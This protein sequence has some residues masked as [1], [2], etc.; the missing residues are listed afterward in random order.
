MMR[1]SFSSEILINK[2]KMRI[3]ITLLLILL[4]IYRINSAFA[5]V[6]LVYDVENTGAAC[7]A[8]PLPSVAQLQSYTNLPDPF[9]WSDGNG[10]ITHF[11]D[12][13]CR[14]NEIKQEIEKYEIGTKPPKPGS[15]T[16]TYS[17]GT[18]TVN[19]TE[20]G[21]TLTLTSKVVVPSGSGPFP[22]VIGM[23]SP[24]GNLPANLFNGVIQIPFNHDQ[25]AKYTQGGRD[26]SYPFFKLY[27]NL[28]SNGY[29]SAWAWGVSR[30]IDGI[31]IVKAQMNADTKRICVTGCSYAGKMALF[32]GAFDERVALTIAQ[33]S[34][35]GG[36]NAWRVS[37]TIGNVEKIDNTN[38]S[39]FMQSLKTNFQGA[40]IGK[41]PYD[42]HELMAMIAPRALLVLGNPPFQWL[43]DESGYV[44]CRAAQEVWKTLGVPD[45][46]GFSFRGGH[47]HC[48][49]PAASNSE[50]TAFV[51]KFLRN[52]T[53]A[54]TNIEVHPF[55]STNYIKWIDA[56]DGYALTPVNPN[57]PKTNL[58][59]P[60]D[61]SKFEAPATVNIA[62]SVTDADNNVTKIEFFAGNQKLGE[63]ATAPYSFSWT[64]VAAG[65]YTITA[66]ASDGSG[67]TDTSQAIAIDVTV[68]KTPFNGIPH[69]IPGVIEAEEYDLGG[70][71]LGYHE[72]NA[73]GNEGGN[74]FRNDQV[75]IETTEDVQGDYNVGYI[76]N[77]EWL[78]YTV[79]AKASGLYNISLRV[80]VDGANRTMHMEM[81]G[82]NITDAIALPN[83]GGWQTWQTITINNLSITAGKHILRLVFD[84]DYLNINYMDFELSTITS[85][86]DAPNYQADIFPNPYT[87]HLTINKKGAFSYQIADISGKVI[88]HGTGI[89]F[90]LVGSNLPNGLYFVTVSNDS[91]RSR[92][93]VMK[94]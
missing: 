28:T 65:N 70:E 59:S 20:N 83:T 66:V 33:E 58:T 25:V 47:D 64:N 23:N 75:D 31:E 72:V 60:V 89:D 36:V 8:P 44:S 43:G 4:N 16:A 68:P 81:D 15:V 52:N 54:N 88:E 94:K 34:G 48:S 82:L 57:A 55:G 13:K 80:A 69:A 7:T 45:R 35:G 61:G 9:A 22:V 74:P 63:D 19:V 26:P 24:T 79:N 10:R 11:D 37:E 1:K 39:W 76:L 56:W 27:P 30:L 18:L 5:Q 71:G 14:R 90:K 3:N 77:G 92:M 51:D 62:A 93:K 6:P 17:G 84:S 42:H 29:Y 32:A 38:Y 2:T 12:W 87:K 78:E 53:S 86:K 41:L 49:L 85:M 46:F 73:N 50:V 21:N 91:G 40:N 67:F